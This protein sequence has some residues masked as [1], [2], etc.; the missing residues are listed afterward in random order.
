MQVWEQEQP[1]R[2]ACST[3]GSQG[4]LE[5]SSFCRDISGRVLSSRAVWQEGLVRVQ[6]L[7]SEMCRGILEISI[8]WDPSSSTLSFLRA[9][10]A[11]HCCHLLWCLCLHLTSV[12][13]TSG[14]PWH[15]PGGENGA[16]QGQRT[17]GAFPGCGCCTVTPALP[18]AD[19][20]VP[21][22]CWGGWKCHSHSSS[23]RLCQC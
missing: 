5:R 18:G 20:E 4:A 2:S 22:G 14:L 7:P 21:Q 11:A 13:G 10:L 17:G 3:P 16:A 8:Q 9:T 23:S 12:L 15:V 19:R 1:S 6:E